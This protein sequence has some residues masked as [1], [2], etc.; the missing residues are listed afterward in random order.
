[1]SKS[2]TADNSAYLNE[3]ISSQLMAATTVILV[4]TTIL[5]CLRLYARTLP[6]IKPGPED[7]LLIAAYILSTASCVTG[8]CECSRDSS[9][10]VSVDSN[11]HSH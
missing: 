9:H 6:S 2:S 4:A 10:V 3:D 8:Y 11:P 1:M 5:F 7:I